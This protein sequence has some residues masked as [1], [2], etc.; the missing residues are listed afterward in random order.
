VQ[1]RAF[2]VLAIEHGDVGRLHGLGSPGAHKDPFD[3]LIIAT[4]LWRHLTIL[5]ADS[6]FT[7]YGVQ[8]LW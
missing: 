8:V 2:D 5:T 7:E 3:R 6:R 1:P 4:A